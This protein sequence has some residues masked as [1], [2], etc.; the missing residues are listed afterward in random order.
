MIQKE[1][2]Y[3]KICPK[4][5]N[6][7]RRKIKRTKRGRWGSSFGVSRREREE[8]RRAE[9]R[10]RERTLRR[11]VGKEE[12]RAQD[13]GKCGKDES[14]RRDI[15]GVAIR[16]DKM[17]CTSSLAFSNSSVCQPHHLHLALLVQLNTNDR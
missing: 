9:E 2:R 1:A 4:V 6:E 16:V 12:I 5:T 11:G 15:K 13:T 8:K 10:T 17:Y 3:T 14:T 7:G